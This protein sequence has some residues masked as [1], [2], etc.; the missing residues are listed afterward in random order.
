MGVKLTGDTGNS[1]AR[2]TTLFTVLGVLGTLGFYFYGPTVTPAL[3]G[4]AS[5]EC[6][7]LAGGNYRS[8]HLSWDVGTRPHWLCGDRSEPA[9]DPVDM[10]WWVTPSF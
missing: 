6:N 5:A 3:H 4:A 9:K 10:G 2:L 8:Y 7:R 1:V